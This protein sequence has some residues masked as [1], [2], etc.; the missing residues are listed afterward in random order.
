MN[1]RECRIELQKQWDSLSPSCLTDLNRATFQTIISSDEWISSEKILAY[2]NFKGEIS[3]DSLILHSLKSKKE[4]FVPRIKKGGFMEFYRVKSLNP[5]FLETN[6]H[7]IRE[8]SKESEKF[9]D[10]PYRVHRIN[11]ND[12]S[13]LLILTP[14]LGFT[15]EGERMGRGGGFYDRFLKGMIE[16]NHCIT[17]GIG[18]EGIILPEIP[19]ESHDRKI[20]KLC[21]GSEIIDCQS[22]N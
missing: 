10:A 22:L 20:R 8:P 14:G 5:S 19:C 6:Y 7:G 21:I 4:V 11:R 13:R 18:W 17:M 1:K 3:L 2:L 16:N 15:R 9:N 12:P